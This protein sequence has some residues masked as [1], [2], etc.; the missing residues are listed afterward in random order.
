[1]GFGRGKGFTSKARVTMTEYTIK[2]GG[3]KIPATL[4]ELVP[5]YITKYGG[6]AGKVTRIELNPTYE[7]ELL[8]ENTE[9]QTEYDGFYALYSGFRKRYAQRLT[10]P[11]RTVTK[12]AFLLRKGGAPTGDITFEIRKVSDDS[13]ICSKVWGDIADLSTEEDW[14]EAAFDTPET[15]NEE[16]RICVLYEG[17]DDTNYLQCAVQTSDVKADEYFCFMATTSWYDAES[18]D[19]T[20]IYSYT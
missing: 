16:V 18:H 17:G 10:I 7:V 8:V 9:E 1:M 5:T 11:D 14:K 12:L 20:Y 19:F 13:L 2:S 4:T 6:G 15:I 3:G